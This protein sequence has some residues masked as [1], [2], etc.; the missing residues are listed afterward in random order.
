MPYPFPPDAKSTITNE[1]HAGEECHSQ[2]P[3]WFLLNQVQT[4]IGVVD[5]NL[6][7]GDE[8]KQDVVVGNKWPKHPLRKIDR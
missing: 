1:R 3:F 4:N 8:S 7:K 2:S 5:G 6:K